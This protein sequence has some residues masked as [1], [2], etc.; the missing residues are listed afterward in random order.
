MVRETGKL[1]KF[2]FDSNGLP[3]GDIARR[4]SDIWADLPFDR[5]SLAALKRDGL[6]LDGVNLGG[7]CPYQI[8]TGDG[9][10]VIVNVA[11]PDAETLLDLWRMHFLR[12]LRSHTLAA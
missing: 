2:G 3:A 4:A 8:A 5:E 1:A 12:G 7:P 6:M 9:G 10:L 11:G